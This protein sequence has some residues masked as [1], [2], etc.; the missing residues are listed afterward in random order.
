MRV[1]EADR[2]ARS[3]AMALA[4]ALFILALAGSGASAQET[5]TRSTADGVYSAEQAKRGRDTFAG[6]CQ[7]CHTPAQLAGPTFVAAW[8][9][10][11][12]WD[13]YSYVVGTMPKSDPGS[14]SPDEYAQTLAYV[15]ELNHMPPGPD[16]LPTDPAALRQ[17][18]LDTASVPGGPPSPR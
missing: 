12:M 8:R 18:R 2:I 15:L 11:T 1:L 6:M 13:L 17:I 3:G 16:D 9:G 7:S 5:P 10:Y 4:I 14:L